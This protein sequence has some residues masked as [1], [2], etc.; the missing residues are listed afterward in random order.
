MGR[1]YV[2]TVID[3]SCGAYA[4]IYDDGT[5]VTATAV[6]IREV[7]W[8]DARGVTVERILPDNGGA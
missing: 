3:D 4:D 2:H 1:V 7:E 5:V 8:F 6:P